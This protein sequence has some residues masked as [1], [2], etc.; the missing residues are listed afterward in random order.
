MPGEWT[1]WHCCISRK[2]N[3]YGRTIGVCGHG[4]IHGYIHGYQRK[5]CGYGYGWQISDP[6]QAWI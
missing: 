2:F 6:Q 3:G 1:L 4:Y 5:I